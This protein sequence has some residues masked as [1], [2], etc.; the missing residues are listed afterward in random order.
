MID[1]LVSNI[2]KIIKKDTYL[3]LNLEKN[4]YGI[5]TIHRPSNVDEKEK[6]E[7]MLKYFKNLSNKI[8]LVLPLHPRTK[9]NIEKF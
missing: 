6:L 1:S 7:Y 8:K 3:K 4:N 5:I 2:D 9:S